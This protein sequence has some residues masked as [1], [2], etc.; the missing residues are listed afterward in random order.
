MKTSEVDAIYR[1]KKTGLMPPDS[2][3]PQA[4]GYSEAGASHVR[5]ALKGFTAQSGSPREDIDS[6]NNTLRQRSRMLYMASPVATSAINTNRTK[7]VGTG[8]TLKCTI[9]REVLGLSPE[10]AKEWQHKTEAEFG[11]WANRRQNCDA[12]GLNNFAAMQQLALKSWLLSG[13]AFVLFKRKAPTP[14]N[15]YGLR[16][17]VIEADR[18]CTPNGVYGGRSI[19]GVTEGTVPD[20]QAGSGHKVHDGVEVDGEGCVVAYHICDH[21]P[22]D[23]TS[24]N[25]TWTRVLATGERTG[26][27]NVLHIMDSE[28]PDQYRGVPYL[29]HVIEPLLQLRRY[30][31]SE[32]WAALIQTFFTAWIETESN[33]LEMPFSE[34]GGG[35]GFEGDAPTG[36]IS[37]DEHEYEMGP[38]VVTHLKKGE[39]IVFG[40]PN[41]PSAGFEKFLDTMCRETGAALE[42]PSDVL[43]K[44]FDAS[45][46][47]AR[48]ALL[49]AWEAMKMRR[50]WFVDDMCRP[51][52]E[53]WLAEAVARGRIKAP[54]FFDDPL[55]RDAWC[56][57]RWIGPVQSQLDPKKEAEAAIL[58]IDRGIK[59]HTQVTREMGGG[60]WEENIEQLARENALLTAAGGNRV[61]Q[62]SAGDDDDDT[63]GAN[64]NA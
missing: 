25:A 10:A 18:V 22:G 49:E 43:L 41:V 7:V 50:A 27:P 16:L 6:N 23:W 14:L 60:D 4:K 37:E 46:S 21:F 1:D 15:P 55:L 13:D 59:T 3:R 29:A 32:L 33:P 51:T 8:L 45:Y 11:L 42:L 20:G 9:D 19:S 57:A 28:R 47:A 62:V 30:T 36:T 31:E 26:L 44:K 39:K 61:T 17:H 54:G 52:Y 48:G 58:L 12:L 64:G 2:L 40:N 53:V 63:R 5:R 38:G 34:I 35:E 56:G 24:T